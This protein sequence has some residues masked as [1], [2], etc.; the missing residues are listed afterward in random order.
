MSGAESWESELAFSRDDDELVNPLISSAIATSSDGITRR[1]PP[2]NVI[3]PCFYIL[4]ILGMWKPANGN[5]ELIWRL[6]RSF[7]YVLWLVCLAAIMSLDFIHYGFAKENIHFREIM[8]SACTCLDL[9]CPYV[10]TLYYFNRGQFANLVFSVQ[11][12]SFEWHRRLSRVA[13]LYTIG[14]VL[15]WGCCATFF[16]LHWIPFFS[17][18]WHY[19]VYIPV[20]VY[21]SGWWGAWL[22]I[23][24]FVCHAH[25]LQID[26]VAERISKTEHT[27]ASILHKHNHLQSSLRRTQEDFNFIIS[28]A[29]SYHVLDLI[30][31]SFAYFSSAFGS[32]YP[33]WQFIGAVLFDVISI[34]FKLYPPAVIAAAS[35]RMVVCASTR[36]HMQASPLSTDLPLEDMHLFQYLALCEPDMGLKILGI[37]IT[38]ELSMKILM[39]IATA[40]V[41]FVVFVV[42][43]LQ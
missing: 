40:V 43:W 4:Q 2:Q 29:L 15:L 31:F 6:Y 32:D 28:F 41:S 10:F 24:S 7:V 20:V 11:N 12:V 9:L 42:P 39:T 23:Y 16:V 37:R 33:M 5:L 14:S 38:V 18:P 36:C 19:A 34:V 21:I 22:S 35:H 17:K 13:W 1:P 26:F 27:A 8:N 30:V 3:R 25:S